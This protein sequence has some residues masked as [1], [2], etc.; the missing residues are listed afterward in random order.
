MCSETLFIGTYICMLRTYLCILLLLVI[1][2]SQQCLETSDKADQHSPALP[3]C[4]GQNV[5]GVNYIS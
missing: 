4:P 5:D 3:F 1:I 2:V